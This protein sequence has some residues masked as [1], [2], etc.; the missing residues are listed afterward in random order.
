MSVRN[1]TKK[2]NILLNLLRKLEFKEPL[3]KKAIERG[4]PYAFVQIAKYLILNYVKPIQNYLELPDLKLEGSTGA[5][6]KLHKFMTTT[7][8]YK[9]QL[10]EKQLISNGFAD[11][12]VLFFLESTK[13]LK[14]QK[15]QLYKSTKS[16]KK[17]SKSLSSDNELPLPEPLS[18]KKLSPFRDSIQSNYTELHSPLRK[19]YTSRFSH[20]LDSTHNSELG[21]SETSSKTLIS[22]VQDLHD[23]MTLM[24]Q[25]FEDFIKHT[26]G[27]LN[28][29]EE[30][31][32]QQSLESSARS[33]LLSNLGI[34][35]DLLGGKPSLNYTK[36]PC[37]CN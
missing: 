2:S 36:T 34:S 15:A 12:K 3:N 8:N 37:N 14:Q 5:L 11:N 19:K 21:Y 6:A 28:L 4:N 23:R 1:V 9:P 35:K 24:E 10:T 30:K 33:G 27:K 22:L 31:L 18:Q 17:R 13:I 7:L 20:F 16:S 29:L 32:S 25:K 26:N